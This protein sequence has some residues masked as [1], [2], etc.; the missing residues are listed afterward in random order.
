MRTTRIDCMQIQILMGQ[1][2]QY[3]ILA[4][5]TKKM[6]GSQSAIQVG[7]VVCLLYALNSPGTNK[8]VKT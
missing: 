2:K 4:L 7:E 5:F 6:K 1:V 8:A 3:F